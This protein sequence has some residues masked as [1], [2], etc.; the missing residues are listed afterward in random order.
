M[1]SNAR[2][3]A[4]SLDRTA[5]VRTF[6][7]VA[8]ICF[9]S[10][11]APILALSFA[12]WC[13]DCW[14]RR[15]RSAPAPA[16]EARRRAPRS[17]RAVAQSCRTAEGENSCATVKAPCRVR[18]TCASDSAEGGEARTGTAVT[19]AVLERF[20]Q[21]SRRCEPATI[22]A[23]GDQMQVWDL[24]GDIRTLA[25]DLPDAA[26]NWLRLPSDARWN[27]LRAC[28]RTGGARVKSLVLAPELLRRIREGEINAIGC[29]SGKDFALA[30]YLAAGDGIRAAAKF[31]RVGLSIS[32]SSHSSFSLSSPMP[33]G[34]MG[35]D[36]SNSPSR[37]RTR[38]AC[39]IFRRTTRSAR[40]SGLC[41]DYRVSDR[42]RGTAALRSQGVS[43]DARHRK[44]AA[45]A[46]QADISG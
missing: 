27:L 40:S 25:R 34:C 45:T 21:M 44:V 33:I 35:R 46:I 42:A 9:T 38:A 1:S 20:P 10:I 28:W 24:S 2:G 16:G 7:H 29:F 39:I 30:R 14:P 17:A 3:P 12:D 6:W 43:R 8:S 31:S 41:P 13:V 26:V 5:N 23:S 19:T 22:G 15:P 32:A 11:R 18:H 36:S 37:P 4:I